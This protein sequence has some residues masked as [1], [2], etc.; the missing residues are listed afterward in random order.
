[1]KKII[2]VKVLTYFKVI[3]DGLINPFL[4]WLNISELDPF[5]STFIGPEDE[6][7][8][9]LGFSKTEFPVV[10]DL[11]IL[12]SSFVAIASHINGDNNEKFASNSFIDPS[13]KIMIYWP[14]IFSKR[15]NPFILIHWN[16][17]CKSYWQTGNWWDFNSVVLVSA[18]DCLP[19]K[20]SL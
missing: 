20:I 8:L 4:S 13:Y 7:E 16:H 6:E 1:M 19:P 9:E 18:I 15:K 2:P 14:I 3:I 10:D 5:E 12:L 17:A 11:L